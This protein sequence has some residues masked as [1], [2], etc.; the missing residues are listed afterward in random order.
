MLYCNAY[1]IT[2]GIRHG[3]MT[4]YQQRVAIALYKQCV[5]ILATFERGVDA[6]TWQ[7][8]LVQ[9][10][11]KRFQFLESLKKCHISVTE[12]MILVWYTNL[13]LP[14]CLKKNKIIVSFGQ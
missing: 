4:L 9:F 14:S 1:I 10:Y 3:V 2:Y 5:W 8:D 7:Y 13:L 12:G 6:K 11:S